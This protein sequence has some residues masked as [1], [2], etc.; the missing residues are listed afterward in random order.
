LFG[1]SGQIGCDL[2]L[3]L[4]REAKRFTH[5]DIYSLYAIIKQVLS[6]VIAID[7]IAVVN[8]VRKKS[9]GAWFQG[10]RVND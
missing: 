3:L 8:S 1:V 4:R 2:C 9:G 10:A 5:I 6:V 7:F